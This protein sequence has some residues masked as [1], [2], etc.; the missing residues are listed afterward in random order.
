MN[1]TGEHP[2]TPSR[3]NNKSNNKPLDYFVDKQ[4]FIIDI[5][6][7]FFFFIFCVIF[8]CWFFH[9]LF[10]IQKKIGSMTISC[11]TDDQIQI[12]V[13]LLSKS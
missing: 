9:I 6:I 13:L 5:I 3:K 11:C 12:L 10:L 1:E 7:F 8:I 2:A 4:L